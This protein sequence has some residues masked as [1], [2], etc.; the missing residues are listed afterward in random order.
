MIVV[1]SIDPEALLERRAAEGDAAY[2]LPSLARVLSRHGVLHFAGAADETQL[3]AAVASLAPDISRIWEE[4][5]ISLEGAGRFWRDEGDVLTH[6]SCLVIPLPTAKL[7]PSDLVVL[8]ESSCDIQ[9]VPRPLPGYLQRS[10]EP[11]LTTA[12]A[13]ATCKTVMH[14]DGLVEEPY[15]GQGE[16]RELTWTN[17]MAP[18]TRLT[19][20]EIE[21]RVLDRYLFRRFFDSRDGD[22]GLL[23]HVD[24]LLGRL[25]ENLSPDA[26]VHLLAEDVARGKTEKEGVWVRRREWAR[27]G[28]RQWL[29]SHAFTLD[30][31]GALLVSLSPWPKGASQEQPL[32]KSHDRHIRFNKWVALATPQGFD[33]VQDEAVFGEDG[34]VLNR[35]L[36]TDS[37]GRGYFASLMRKEEAVL[38]NAQWSFP[39][40]DAPPKH[41]Q[42]GQIRNSGPSSIVDAGLQVAAPQLDV[43]MDHE[44]VSPSR[45]SAQEVS[46]HHFI[47]TNQRG[48]VVRGRVTKLVQSGAVVRLAEGIEELVPSS[49]LAGRVVKIGDEIL[50]RITHVDRIR[51][52]IRLSLK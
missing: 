19:H 38:E 31:P 48:Q 25:N 51:R 39:G 7:W 46:W 17:Y 52:R 1:A 23:G 47:R 20:K 14:I 26:K 34:M 43:Q 33:R 9:G 3:R 16:S 28:L 45:K 22:V 2:V 49:E 50:V 6:D 8:C 4:L 27:Q 35:V 21:V 13:V 30:R 44:G 42:R 37:E 15:T 29:E 10:G 12:G 40:T 32:G 11:E 18:L 36:A 5:L 24:W 41:L